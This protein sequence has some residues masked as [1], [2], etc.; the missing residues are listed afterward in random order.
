MERERRKGGRRRRRRRRGEPEGQHARIERWASSC[1]S[2]RPGLLP[3]PLADPLLP[4]PPG[5]H[6]QPCF[7]TG[8]FS[9]PHQFQKDPQKELPW[10]TNSSAKTGLDLCTKFISR[11]PCVCVFPTF[12]LKLEPT[13]SS[14]TK[15]PRKA[16]VGPKRGWEERIP[17]DSFC[18]L[19]TEKRS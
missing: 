19:K 17:T 16:F 8:S 14:Q 4:S 2:D 11:S 9:S 10:Q 15:K 3:S 12:L 5:Y 13:K 18:K 7:P 6:P 1:P